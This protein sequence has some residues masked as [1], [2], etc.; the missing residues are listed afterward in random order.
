M[1]FR[2]RKDCHEIREFPIP[3]SWFSGI[4][5]ISP[6][7]RNNIFQGYPVDVHYAELGIM[8]IILSCQLCG[9]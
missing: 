5:G 2:I 7:P 4:T 3:S 9:V 1:E 8:D 6:C